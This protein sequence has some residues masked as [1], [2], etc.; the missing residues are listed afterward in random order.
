MTA[1]TLLCFVQSNESGRDPDSELLTYLNNRYYVWSVLK[2]Q[3]ITIYV[4]I[5][6]NEQAT[7]IDTNGREKK[8]TSM[9]YM[10]TRRILLFIKET[11][12]WAISK[13]C[14]N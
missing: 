8:D 12:L 6:G 3:K 2:A 1:V 9:C 4:Q 5:A 7:N 11:S 10:C 14:N 13:L